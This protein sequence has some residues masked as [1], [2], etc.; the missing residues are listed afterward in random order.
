MG[1]NNI[2]IVEISMRV[3]IMTSVRKAYILE[4]FTYDSV[5]NLTDT[6]LGG[7][8]GGVN[9]TPVPPINIP[10]GKCGGRRS[11]TLDEYQ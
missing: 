7:R 2:V 1:Y 3:S 6:A 10:T 5:N 8:G 4:A 9:I 11:K